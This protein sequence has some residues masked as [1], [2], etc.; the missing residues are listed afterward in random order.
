MCRIRID[1]IKGKWAWGKRI[2]L[3]YLINIIYH[4]SQVVWWWWCKNGDKWGRCA[5]LYLRKGWE[6]ADD[7][8]VKSCTLSKSVIGFRV[9]KAKRKR[10]HDRIARSK[11]LVNLIVV[12]SWYGVS[13][14]SSRN[15]VSNIDNCKSI[16]DWIQK[17]LINITIVSYANCCC[18]YHS[19]TKNSSKNGR[20]LCD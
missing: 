1:D 10:C 5:Y 9:N 4:C 6:I 19:T 18:I 11:L 3:T 2:N 8:D 13:Q 15:R 14:G 16:F 7:W 12:L 17:H 20:F